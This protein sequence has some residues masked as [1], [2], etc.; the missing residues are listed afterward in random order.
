MHFLSH[1]YT[2]LPSNNPLFVV[3]LGIPD[4]TPHFARAY[5][6]KLKKA[7][8]PAEHELS[9]I[10]QGVLRHFA[11]DAKFHSSP[12]F[13]QQVHQAVASMVKEG[14]NRERLRLSVIAHLAVEMLIDRQIVIQQPHVC[15]EYYALVGNADETVLHSYF[16]H[17]GLKQE[18]NVFSERFA[19]FRQRQFI[20]LFNDLE[21]IVFG[22]NRIYNAVTKVELT[23]N[24]KAQLK[25]ALYNIDNI[26][27]YRW[28]EILQV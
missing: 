28:Q 24:E 21:N 15:N 18:K 10:H 19:F 16:I 5:N 3:A 14:M 4:L 27:R 7:A 25:A 12:I 22:L 2:E 17:F 23:V 13:V 1:Y 26:I 20:F 8:F 9:S 11:G 6:S